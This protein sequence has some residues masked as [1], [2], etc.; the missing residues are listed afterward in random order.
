MIH[1]SP[2][3]AVTFTLP[4]CR[5]VRQRRRQPVRPVRHPL[6]QPADELVL[7]L[8]DRHV[9]HGAGRLEVAGQ[10]VLRVAPPPPG[11]DVDLS[12]PGRAPQRHRHAQLVRDA[13]DFALV[14]EDRLAPIPE[15]DAVHRHDVTGVVEARL[16]VDVGVLGQQHEPVHHRPVGHV[17][18][19]EAQRVQQR[20]Q[21]LPVVRAV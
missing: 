6:L 2:L 12:A 1:G 10:V 5:A 21:H 7:G 4:A 14:V 15:Y 8:T 11:L 16:A 20:R 18:A 3:W 19:L 13:L 9:V 17:L